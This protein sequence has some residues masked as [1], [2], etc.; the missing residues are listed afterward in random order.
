M[1]LTSAR[2]NISM[3]LSTSLLTILSSLPAFSQSSCPITKLR[4][5]EVIGRVVSQGKREV[6]VSGTKVELFRLDDDVLIKSVLTDEK[7]LF[8][9][10]N[11]KNGKYRLLVWFTLEGRTYLKYNLI[12]KISKNQK[13]RN[14]MVNV[15]LGIDCF[16]SDVHLID[17]KSLPESP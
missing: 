11:V 6:P 7:G 10:D 15:R 12:L 17:A 4:V 1:Q 13:K 8:K 5:G 2:N 16:D 14:Q 9:I 3:I